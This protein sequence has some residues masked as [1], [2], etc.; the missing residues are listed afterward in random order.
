MHSLIHHNKQYPLLSDTWRGSNTV[1]IDGIMAALAQS[2]W[3][4]YNLPNTLE[5][6][7]YLLFL[8]VPILTRHKSVLVVLDSFMHVVSWTFLVY[9]SFLV[10]AI[11]LLVQ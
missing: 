10:T 5:R 2:S 4:L 9:T 7:S 8:L 1:T 3:F 6:L 11:G